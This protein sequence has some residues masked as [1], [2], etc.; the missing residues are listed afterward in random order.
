MPYLCTTWSGPGGSPFLLQAGEPP[1]WGALFGLPSL[2]IR[3][4]YLALATIGAYFIIIWVLM[5]GGTLTGGINGLPVSSPNFFGIDIKTQR[6]F[7]YLIM[8]FSI[9]MVFFAKNIVRGRL[10]RAFIAI[11]DNDVAAEFIGI[12]IFG[13]KLVAFAISSAYAGISGS[14]LATYW[15]YISFEQFPFMDNIWYVSFIIVGGMG[16]IAG[17]IFWCGFYETDQQRSDVDRTDHREGH[18][19]SS[20]LSCL[21][22]D[23]DCI[24]SDHH[25]FFDIRTSGFVPSLGSDKI[26]V[27]DLALYVLMNYKKSVIVTNRYQVLEEKRILKMQ[28]NSRTTERRRLVRK[29]LKEQS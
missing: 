29:S 21:S 22:F 11:R 6:E 16:S 19:F 9:I 8:G 5:H 24:W 28:S 1:W 7:F 13:Y 26:F 10:G 2:R 27:S 18:P 3:G 17:T 4:F 15:A 25:P 20:G 23:D 14:L 12:N